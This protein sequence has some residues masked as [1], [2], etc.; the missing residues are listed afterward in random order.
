MKNVTLRQLRTLAAVVDEGSFSGAAKALHLTQPA[1]SLQVKELERACGLPLVER[2]RRRVRLTEAGHELLHAAQGVERELKQAQESISAL[3]GLRGG[4]LT[5]AVISTAQYFAPRLLA[6]FCR[7]HAD[8]QLRLD[9]CNRAAIIGHLERDDVDVAIMGRPPAEL[10]IACEAEPFA[11]HPHI[12]IAPAGHPLTKRRRIPVRA[13]LAEPFVSREP[14]SGTRLIIQTLFEKKGL[15]FAPTMVMNSNETIKQAVIA[16]MGLSFL[17]LHTVGLEIATGTLAP[18]DVM[19]TPVVRRWYLAHRKDKRL[20]PP[21]LAFRAFMLAEAAAFM[22]AFM[23][24]G[25]AV[26]SS[27]VTIK[28]R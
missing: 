25:S 24:H 26:P 1:V 23:P 17:S 12:A 6:E 19:G 4:K 2:S 13:L 7:R 18:L 20:A 11:R 14:G 27:R 8:V 10:A 9:V 16:G 28:T 5:V 22:E 21:A 15:A 3:K